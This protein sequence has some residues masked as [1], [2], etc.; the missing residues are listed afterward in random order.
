MQDIY[1]FKRPKWHAAVGREHLA[2]CESAVLFDQSSFAKFVLKGPDAEAV[3]GWNTANDVSGLVGSL[4]CTQ[5]LNYQC[6]IKCDLTCVRMTMDKFYIVTGAGFVTHDFNHI[7]KTIPAGL[8][9][10]LFDVMSAYA[11]LSLF[12]PNSRSILQVITVDD[13]GNSSFP[14]GWPK[15]SPLPDVCCMRCGSA[16]WVNW[17]GNCSCR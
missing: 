12:G 7:A 8:N 13:L 15:R 9:A 1:T 3:L 17:A 6:G 5:M 10:Q 16:M 4:T 2:A 11:V 14:F